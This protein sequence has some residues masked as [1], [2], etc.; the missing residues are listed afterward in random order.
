M[1]HSNPWHLIRPAIVVAAAVAAVVVMSTSAWAHPH[2]WVTV[3]SDLIFAPD[4]SLTSVRHAWA[5]D[6]MFSTFAIQGLKSKT[7][8]EFTREELAPLAETNV[9]SLKE[10]EYFTY[11]K[12][13]GKQVEFVDPPADYYLDFNKKESVLTLNFTVPLKRPVK[14]KEFKLEVYDREFFIDF[15]LAEK[16]PALLRR[17]AGTMQAHSAAAA[18]N[19]CCAGAAAEPA[20]TGPAESIADHRHRIRQQDI[21]EM[22]VRTVV[23]ER[24]VVHIFAVV[25]VTAGVLALAGALDAAL[26]QAGPL[27]VSRP[28]ALAAPVSG[29]LGWIFVKQAEFYRQF[30]SL[31][32]AAKADGTAAW[33]LFALS[34]LY[35]IFHAAGPGHGKA[36]ISSYMVANEETWT[37]GVV[38]VVRLRPAAGLGRGSGGRHRCRAVECDGGDHE[39][40]GKCHRNREL[41]AD[42]SDRLAVAMGEGTRL[43]RSAA[44]PSSS[45]RRRGRRNPC[46]S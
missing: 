10:Y 40:R 43:H 25:A 36:V 9:T 19:E 17:R 31:I 14:V 30:S 11:A 6:D 15:S 5:F 2:V 28:Q 1:L 34:F 45:R 22:P 12:A 33:S 32:R 46:A 4:G 35:G 8:G 41:L 24:L 27:G 44:R 20:R 16:E 37:R 26:A 39:P 7:K 38:L 3:K 42:R 18:G 29:V 13:N 23:G 21:G